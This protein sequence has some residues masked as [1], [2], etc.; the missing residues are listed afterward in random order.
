MYVVRVAD[1]FHY[2]DQNEHYTHGTYA[3]WQE[4]VAAAHSI[5]DRCLEEYARPGITADEL[6]AQYSTFGDD[7]F[8]VPTPQGESFS[9]WDYAKECCAKL[10]I[11]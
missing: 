2:M 7:P 6:F 1:N 10:C 3:T 4:A 11:K 9:G 8:I 5:V